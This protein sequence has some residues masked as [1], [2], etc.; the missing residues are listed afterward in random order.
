MHDKIFFG[1]L[2]SQLIS[3]IINGAWR[4]YI[5]HALYS[6]NKV[7]LRYDMS[8][9]IQKFSNIINTVITIISIIAISINMI[10]NGG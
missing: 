1:I 2:L 3:L 8:N 6:Y 7:I 5:T 10:Y 9:K 4:I